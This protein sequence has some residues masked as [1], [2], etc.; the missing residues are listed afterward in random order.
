MGSVALCQAWTWSVRR[1][2]VNNLKRVVMDLQEPTAFGNVFKL[3]ETMVIFLS[4]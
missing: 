3:S 1:A 4:V 2:D